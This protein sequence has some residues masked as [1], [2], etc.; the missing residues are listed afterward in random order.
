MSLFRREPSLKEAAT[1]LLRQARAEALELFDPWWLAQVPVVTAHA[2]QAIA[3]QGERG[4]NLERRL[5]TVHDCARA[6]AVEAR[7]DVA[8][9]GAIADK[10]PDAK[11]SKQLTQLLGD[12]YE[13][14][15]SVRSRWCLIVTTYG[16]N[17]E[18]LV[19]HFAG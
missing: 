11:D 16:I 4:M 3:E 7:L 19:R 2:Q 14:D 9:K 13:R 17:V 15:A 6:L 1:T 5:K 8:A 18:A 12:F 10:F